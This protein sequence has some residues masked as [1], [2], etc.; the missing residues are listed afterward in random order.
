MSF[1]LTTLAETT[2]ETESVFG[3]VEAP[4]GVAQYDV[5]AGGIGLILFMPVGFTFL[6]L[7][8]LRL[9]QKLPILLFIV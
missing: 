8:K 4:P 2:T 1:F 9:L 6:L 7:E 3:K 5:A